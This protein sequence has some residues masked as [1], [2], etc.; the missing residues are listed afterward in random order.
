MAKDETKLR[1]IR[2]KFWFEDIVYLKVRNDKDR[3]LITGV[4]ISPCGGIMYEVQWPETWNTHHEIE[5]SSEFEPD[6]GQQEGQ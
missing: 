3:G 6:Y 5:L 2:T 1:T 4:T